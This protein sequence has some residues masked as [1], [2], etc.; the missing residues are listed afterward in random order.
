MSEDEI[1]ELQT[2]LV[3]LGWLEVDSFM[4]GMLD[5]ATVYAISDFQSYCNET[6]D[7][8]LPIIDPMNPIIDADTLDVLKYA[9]ES[10]ANP[11]A[12]L[13]PDD[14][15]ESGNDALDVYEEAEAYEEAEEAEEYEEAEAYEEA[16]AY[17]EAEEADGYEETEEDADM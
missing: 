17:E 3:S 1:T 12:A 8:D 9:D 7:L 4:P 11:S 13:L 6:F 14:A 2:Q 15:P 10:Y 5:D 16:D